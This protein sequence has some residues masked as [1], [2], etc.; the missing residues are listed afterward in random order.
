M[1]IQTNG[2][3]MFGDADQI[4]VFSLSFYLSLSFSP[5]GFI[6]IIFN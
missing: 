1:N 2:K 5:S 3:L 6:A 4:V